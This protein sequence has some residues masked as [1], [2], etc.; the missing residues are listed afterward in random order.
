MAN[1]LCWSGRI[2]AA[3][4]SSQNLTH[5]ASRGD[6]LSA[7]ANAASLIPMARPEV[8]GARAALR[9][10]YPTASSAVTSRLGP[11]GLLG[12]IAGAS[13][14]GLPSM[15]SSGISG[16][17]VPTSEGGREPVRDAADRSRVRYLSGIADVLNAGPQTP[18]PEIATQGD[19]ATDALTAVPARDPSL[20]RSAGLTSP[21]A[22]RPSDR[23]AGNGKGLPFIKTAPSIIAPPGPTPPPE[24]DTWEKCKQAARSRSAWANYCANVSEDKSCWGEYLKRAHVKRG[25]CAN[26]FSN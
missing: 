1:S 8:S 21:M 25:W 6:A 7:A 11:T 2:S 15:Q 22:R 16:L 3:S 4:S 13:A 5:A 9:S 14:V 20:E 10:A 19:G 23:K 18:S 17:G 24:P 12:L 26:R